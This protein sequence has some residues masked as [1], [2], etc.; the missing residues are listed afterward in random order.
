MTEAP[1]ENKCKGPKSNPFFVSL[2]ETI[3]FDG[4]GKEKKLSI[5]VL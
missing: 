3:D 1:Q 2:S 5:L 4:R